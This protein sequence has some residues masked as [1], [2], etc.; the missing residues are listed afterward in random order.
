MFDF[1]R[2]SGIMP[3]VLQDVDSGDVL[4]VGYMNRAA[5]HATIGT[6]W[7]TLL[8]RRSGRLFLPRT[9]AGGPLAA[10]EIRMDARGEALLAQVRTARSNLV[11]EGD[12]DAGFSTLVLASD[13]QAETRSR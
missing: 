9:A 11:C 12:L 2:M 4:M 13:R 10:C 8:S 5:L 3:T 6:G 1:S 7:I